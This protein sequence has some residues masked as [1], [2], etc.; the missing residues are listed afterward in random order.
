[1]QSICKIRIKVVAQPQIHLQIGLLVDGASNTKQ[2]HIVL[3]RRI[4]KVDEQSQKSVALA[5]L[6]PILCLKY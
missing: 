2:Q 3:K 4:S 6:S 1:M 5:A